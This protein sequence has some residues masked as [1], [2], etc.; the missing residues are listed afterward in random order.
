MYKQNQGSKIDFVFI[1]HKNPDTKQK[2]RKSRNNGNNKYVYT[3]VT[4]SGFL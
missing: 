2:K 4:L 3:V 1:S